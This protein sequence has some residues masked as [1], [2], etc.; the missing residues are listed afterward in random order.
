[1][2]GGREP[3][4][5]VVVLDLPLVGVVAEARVDGLG[6]EQQGAE[7]VAPDVELRRGLDSA[8]CRSKRLAQMCSI[9]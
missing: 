5:G 6:Q 8:L 1:M 3:V 9:S 2:Q 4:L 7:A